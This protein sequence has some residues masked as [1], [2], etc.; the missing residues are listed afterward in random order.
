M[1]EID[2]Q[3]EIYLGIDIYT[4]L[5]PVVALLPFMQSRSFRTTASS[6]VE[7]QAGLYVHGRLKA[8]VTFEQA[9]AELTA[10]AARFQAAYP[11]TNAGVEVIVDRLS[12]WRLR[13]YRTLLWAFQ[14]AVFLLWLIVT[15]NV[16]N[17]MLARAVTR[18]RQYAI[19]AALGAGSLRTLRPLLIESL[20]LS[21]IAGGGGLLIAL[22]VVQLLRTMT[23]F[24]RWAALR[25]TVKPPQ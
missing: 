3:K 5:E 19:S 21:L 15:T 13:S 25:A 18:R 22:G 24:D 2:T 9:Q 23:P 20:M 16:A 7:A 11:D 10:T 1:A 4:P 14:A 6:S 17:L 8:G 12:E